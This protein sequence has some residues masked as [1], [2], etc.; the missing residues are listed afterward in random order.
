MISLKN[1]LYLVIILI[2]LVSK[3]IKMN[4]LKG[5]KKKQGLN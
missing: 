5:K 3:H 1:S 4:S 2:L